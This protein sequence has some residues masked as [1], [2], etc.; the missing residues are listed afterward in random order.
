MYI[1]CIFFWNFTLE[2][3]EI[4]IVVI[5]LVLFLVII[6]GYSEET[7]FRGYLLEGIKQ[8]YSIKFSIVMNSFIFSILHIFNPGITLLG[9]CNIIIVGFVFYI[10]YID[11][12]VLILL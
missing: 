9:I 10:G 12:I 4:D 5:I 7:L 8:N 11:L 2:F 1:Y 6:Q 3:N